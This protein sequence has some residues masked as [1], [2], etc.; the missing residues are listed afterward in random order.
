MKKIVTLG[1]D[2]SYPSIRLKLAVTAQK[3]VLDTLTDYT[4]A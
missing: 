3:D 1:V 2:A 4:E